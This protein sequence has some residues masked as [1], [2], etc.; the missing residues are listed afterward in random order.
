[1]LSCLLA[2]RIQRNPRKKQNNPQEIPPSLTSLLPNLHNVMLIRRNAVAEPRIVAMWV[3]SRRRLNAKWPLKKWPSVGKLQ[4]GIPAIAHMCL[5]FESLSLALVLIGAPN[6]GE[7]P[8]MSSISS[9]WMII[10]D[11]DGSFNGANY[12]C[13]NLKASSPSSRTLEFINWT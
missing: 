2:F 11:L 4:Q 8:W 13:W 10:V 12:R 7:R 9:M 6:V 5:Q 3:T 1:M